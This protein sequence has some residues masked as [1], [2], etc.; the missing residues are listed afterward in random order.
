MGDTRRGR[1]EG[2]H[3]GRRIVSRDGPD[4]IDEHVG[5][6]LRQQRLLRGLTQSGLAK[7]V[8]TT[9]QQVQKYGKGCNRVSASNLYK[10]AEFLGVDVSFFFRGLD[11]DEVEGS[12]YS[13]RTNDFVADALIDGPKSS[14]EIL[15]LANYY[16]QIEDIKIRKCVLALL[17]GLSERDTTLKHRPLS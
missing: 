2:T 6:R 1:G 15:Q 9:F 12:F 14:R 5:E 3:T 11:I 17:K 4:P 7:A 8:G 10:F 13:R 16:V